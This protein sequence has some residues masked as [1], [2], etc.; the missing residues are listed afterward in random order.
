M[1]G[2]AAEKVYYGSDFT[3]LGAVQ[4]LKQANQLA[5]KMIGNFG[6]GDK[7][8][9]FFNEN[10]NDENT[11]FYNNKYSEYTKFNMDKE[12]IQLII[13]AYNES[14]RILNENKDL[15]YDMRDLLLNNTVITKKDIPHY[16]V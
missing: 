4:D 9:V 13:E 11:G 7:I 16:F 3:S 12:T 8:E 2:K 5:Q 6:M 14:L 10:I 1:G 15:L